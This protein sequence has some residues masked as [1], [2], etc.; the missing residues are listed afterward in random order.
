MKKRNSF[1]GYVLVGI[2]TYFL[3]RELEIPVLKNFYSWPTLLMIIGVALIIHS[4]NSRDYQHLFS[5]T[6]LAGLGIHFHG[7]ENYDFWVDHW[8]VYPLIVGI[9]FLVR[10][11]KTKNGL[12]PAVVLIGFSAIMLSSVRIPAWLGWIYTAIDYLQKFWPIVLIVLGIYFLK[13]KK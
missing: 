12:F 7:L 6:I 2:G 3:L 8:A 9:A 5:G 4:Y 10:Y 11:I 13:K 1:T